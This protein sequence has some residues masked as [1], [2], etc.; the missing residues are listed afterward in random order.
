[1]IEQAGKTPEL[2]SLPRSPKPLPSR[3]N[4][5]MLHFPP[6]PAPL[7]V[8]SLQLYARPA[9]HSSQSTSDHGDFGLPSILWFRPAVTPA[10]VY[11]LVKSTQKGGGRLSIINLVVKQELQH[12]SVDPVI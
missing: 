4:Q 11:I 1:M 9:L 3:S 10:S 7:N 6:W 2:Q 12:V 5:E 8:I